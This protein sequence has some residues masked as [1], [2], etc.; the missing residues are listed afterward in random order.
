MNGRTRP[1]AGSA[2]TSASVV[3]VIALLLTKNIPDFFLDAKLR[4]LRCSAVGSGEYLLTRQFIDQTW[5][6]FFGDF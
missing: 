4:M 2:R 3:C 6:G 1:H 5:I